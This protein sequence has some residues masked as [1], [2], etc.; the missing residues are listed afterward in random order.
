MAGWPA[1]WLAGWLAGWMDA[2][3]EGF[4]AFSVGRA[5]LPYSFSDNVSVCRAT[6]V[7]MG[8]KGTDVAKEAADMVILDDDFSTIM[9]AVEE[10]KAIFYNLRTS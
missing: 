6:G 1:G 4:V 10:G 5:S 9:A 8:L 3:T 2:S 7:A